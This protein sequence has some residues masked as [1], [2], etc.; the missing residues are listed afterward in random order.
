MWK[1]FFV[2]LWS[3]FLLFL[4]CSSRSLQDSEQNVRHGS[5]V[6][7]QGPLV[8]ECT[9]TDKDGVVTID[10]SVRSRD[11]S[12][13]RLSS[14]HLI[15]LGSY[16]QLD[17]LKEKFWLQ[18]SQDFP[19]DEKIG[20]IVRGLTHLPTE[21][22]IEFPMVGG[23]GIPLGKEVEVRF[24]FWPIRSDYKNNHSNCRI[25]HSDDM[26]DQEIEVKIQVVLE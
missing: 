4:G 21:G 22:H 5:G 18:D 11:G 12:A 3:C 23:G 24:L 19:I 20:C 13:L 16:S 6:I 9:V 25:N 14:G 15:Y 17:S 8:V 10:Y 2:I 7:E 26:I 1:S